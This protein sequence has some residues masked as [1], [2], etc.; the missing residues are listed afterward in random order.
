VKLKLNVGCTVLGIV[1]CSHYGAH[2]SL[3]ILAMLIFLIIIYI[4]YFILFYIMIIIII[5]YNIVEIIIN[6]YFKLLI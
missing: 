3:F 1:P 6:M 5:I 2:E 4:N